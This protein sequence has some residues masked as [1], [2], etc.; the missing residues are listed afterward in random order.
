[1]NREV[2]IVTD[3][4]ASVP[5]DI[6]RKYDIAIVPLHIIRKGEDLG[7]LNIDRE[8]FRLWNRDKGNL[9]MTSAPSIGE[10]MEMWQKLA[11]QER[12]ILHITMSSRMGMEYS[13]ALQAR[14]LV[15]K[16]LPDA[17]IEVVDS[18]STQAAEMFVVLGAAKAAREGKIL[19]D[20]KEIS[21]S[22]VERV[23]Q[24][25]LLDTFYNLVQGGRGDRIKMWDGAAFSMKP[26]L[27]LGAYTDGV[28]AP[29]GRV[30]TKAKG[31][32]QMI[33]IL[34]TRVGNKKLHAGITIGDVPD[35]AQNLKECLVTQFKIAELYLLE[36]SIVAD[37]HDGPGALRLGFYSED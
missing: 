1:M 25:Y 10:I 35:E 19:A 22:M 4:V 7:E 21:E 3:T 16:E 27:E 2:A 29:L 5:P 12:D 30:R 32:D 11:L 31:I 23:T 26:L 8:Q 9:P 14:S 13:I 18:L 6:I 24:F 33:E 15:Q 37:V 17:G 20:V 28:M 34:K 36:G